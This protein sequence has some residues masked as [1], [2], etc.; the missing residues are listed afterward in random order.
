MNLGFIIITSVPI[1]QTFTTA[2]RPNKRG[3]D[4]YFSYVFTK[5]YLVSIT[6]TYLYNFDPLKPHFYIV[7]LGFTGVSIIYFYFCSKT[8]IVGTQ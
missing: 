6:K 5:T 3:Y 1:F 7:K 4:K 8:E 2:L